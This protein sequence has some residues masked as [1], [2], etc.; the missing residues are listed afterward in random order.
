MLANIIEPSGNSWC[1]SCIL[2]PNTDATYIS[3]KDFPRV[4]PVTKSDSCPLPTSDG[5]IERIGSAEFMTKF[6]L[7]KG[8]QQVPFTERAKEVHVFVNPR[9]CPVE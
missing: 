8:F 3:C 1:S 7:L 9:P 4:N 5:C 2:V 6:D